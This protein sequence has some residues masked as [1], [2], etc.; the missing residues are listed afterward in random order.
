MAPPNPLPTY[1]YKIVTAEPP[2]PL[3]AKY[4]LSGLDQRDGFI[5][6]ST[7]AQVPITTGFFFGDFSRLWLVKVRLAGLA[8]PVDWTL[9][10]QFPHLRGNFGAD[11]IADV[12][13]YVRPGL[14]AWQDV[15]VD[16]WL[17]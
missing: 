8:D 9:G 2:S 12:R 5:H 6:L 4:P 7:A 16:D 10:D 1:V 14:Q 15:F 17:E 11:D 13:V 3:P